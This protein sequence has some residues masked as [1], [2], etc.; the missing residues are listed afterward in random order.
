MLHINASNSFTTD[1]LADGSLA[2]EEL[3]SILSEKNG[4]NP[5]GKSDDEIDRITKRLYGNDFNDMSP[6]RIGNT[7]SFLNYQGNPHIMIG[8]DCKFNFFKFLIF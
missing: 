5:A 7:Y 2:K 3:G 6:K 1:L 8:Q 4:I